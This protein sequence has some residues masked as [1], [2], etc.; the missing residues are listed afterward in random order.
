[1]GEVRIEPVEGAGDDVGEG[2]NHQNGEE[3]DEEQ[4]ETFSQFPDI[5][6]D[7]VTD[8]ASL[9]A[10]RGEDGAEILNRTD[11]NTSNEDP[12]QDGNPAEDGGLDRAVDWSCSSNRSELVAEYHLSGGWYIVYSIFHFQGRGFALGINTPLFGQIA[13]IDQVRSYK[14]YDG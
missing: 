5:Q 14:H 11:E 9:I 12:K 2:C 7:D 10:N 13:S 4:K 3:P 6:L 1:M 8:G